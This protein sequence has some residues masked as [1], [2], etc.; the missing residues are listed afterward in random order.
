M[1]LNRAARTLHRT[2]SSSM[3]YEHLKVDRRGALLDVTLNRPKKLNALNLDMVR[4]L[5][6]AFDAALG[7]F[8]GV[9]RRLEFAHHV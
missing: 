6:S 1:R 2:M 3:A 9:E 4:E 5:Q 8:G 7:R